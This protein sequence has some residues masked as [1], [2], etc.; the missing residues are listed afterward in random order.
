MQSSSSFS[1]SRNGKTRPSNLLSSRPESVESM[2]WPSPSFNV[3]NQSVL[4]VSADPDRPSS[5]IKSS[6]TGRLPPTPLTATYKPTTL[7][8]IEDSMLQLPSVSNMLN[9]TPPDL[10]QPKSRIIPLPP[11]NDEYAPVNVDAFSHSNIQSDGTSRMPKSTSKTGIFQ[12][13]S[14][15]WSGDNASFSQMER[16]PIAQRPK[17]DRRQSV[18]VSPNSFRNMPSSNEVQGLGLDLGEE[19]PRLGSCG[20]W[21]MMTP[22]LSS[23]QQLPSLPG[24]P[25]MSDMQTGRFPS[26]QPSSPLKLPLRNWNVDLRFENRQFVPKHFG[27]RSNSDDPAIIATDR[28]K[29]AQIQ[30]DMPMSSKIWGLAIST[31]DGQS[32]Q[33]GP[34]LHR[35]DGSVIGAAPAQPVQLAVP[36]TPTQGSSALASTSRSGSS[37]SSSSS[38]GASRTKV[39]SPTVHSSVFKKSTA[40]TGLTPHI[41]KTRLTPAV[42]SSSKGKGKLTGSSDSVEIGSP[43]L[44][45]KSKQRSD[46]LREQAEFIHSHGHLPT[47][48]PMPTSNA[49]EST[50]SSSP[51]SPAR[52]EDFAVIEEFHCKTAPPKFSPRNKRGLTVRKEED[53]LQNKME[54]SPWGVFGINTVHDAWQPLGPPALSKVLGKLGLNEKSTNNS[55]PATENN[56]SKK[57]RKDVGSKASQ[58][59]Q[60][61]RSVQR[62]GSEDKENDVFGSSASMKKKV[63]ASSMPPSPKKSFSQFGQRR[64]VNI[65]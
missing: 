53:N 4:T 32:F 5:Q 51:T 56:N 59:F 38:G 34:L 37:S 36:P 6:P 27:V 65:R 43:S 40:S 9:L 11:M 26:V 42:S 33:R 44:K 28:D 15:E 57:P 19:T 23:H 64:M 61:E 60:K 25:Q 31:D 50:S 18:P 8:P 52:E 41:H 58:N 13:A 1:K 24:A 2:P 39:A 20:S 10:Y 16:R 21:S 22:T 17:I 12:G 7:P 29:V 30:R 49:L 63:S 55:N 14:A 35:A 45:M 54:S 48:L 47:D 46:Q 3:S 62:F